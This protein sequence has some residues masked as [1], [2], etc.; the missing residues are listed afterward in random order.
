[1]SLFPQVKVLVLHVLVLSFMVKVEIAHQEHVLP[2]IS[3]IKRDK[4][5]GERIVLVGIPV[6][7]R[8]YL[9][10]LHLPNM[11]IIIIPDFVKEMYKNVQNKQ[12]NE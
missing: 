12:K 8:S 3:R 1:M 7:C 2:K 9:F 4:K 11:G 6:Y 10:Y 5:E